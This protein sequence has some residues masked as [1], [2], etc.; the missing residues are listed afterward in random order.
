MLYHKR[1]REMIPSRWIK[2]CLLSFATQSYQDFDLV[3]L[4]Y[5]DEAE[6]SLRD[7]Y[8]SLFPN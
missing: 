4:N 5:H 6:R 8:G 2:K 3:D 1:T 7:E